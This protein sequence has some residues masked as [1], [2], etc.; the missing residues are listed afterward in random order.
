MVAP[1]KS[2]PDLALTSPV[3]WVYKFKEDYFHPAVLSELIY[4]TVCI[5]R[6]RTKCKVH[7][8]M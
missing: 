4:T 1:L 3:K 5:K 7:I 6:A 2:P 8:L